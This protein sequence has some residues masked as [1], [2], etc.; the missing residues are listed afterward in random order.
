MRILLLDRDG[1]LNEER[2]YD[3]TPETIRLMPGVVDGLKRLKNWKLFIISNQSSVGRGLSTRKNVDACHARLREL[4][5]KEGIHIAD[6]VYCPHAPDESCP[7]RKSKTGMWEELA[8]RHDLRAEECVMVGNRDSDI[9][10]ARNIGCAAFRIADARHPMNTPPDV[11]IADMTELADILLET[12]RS[13]VIAL[14]D[15]VAYSAKMRKAGKRVVTTNGA[16]DMLHGGHR[17]LFQEARK[18]GDV[19]IVGVNSDASVRRSKGDGRPVEREEIRA[20]KVARHADAAF[21]FDDDD[22]REWLKKISP[23]A[24]AN[25]ESYGKDCVES[26]V[27]REIGAKLALIPVRADLGSTSAILLNCRA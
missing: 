2:D 16:F 4:L 15:A 3:Y 8:A 9:V 11:C 18:H 12:N 17:F 5:R 7:C 6:I 19:L 21:I 22:P 10:F 13:R 24:H 1:V 20:L 25:A 14:S 26:G 27:L 23:A